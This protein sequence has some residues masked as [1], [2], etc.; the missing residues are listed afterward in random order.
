M[1]H[2]LSHFENLMGIQLKSSKIYLVFNK[3]FYSIVLLTV[4]CLYVLQINLA[5]CRKL[6]KF[7]ATSGLKIKI[8]SPG[9]E[10]KKQ[11]WHGAHCPALSV[12]GVMMQYR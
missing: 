10:Q 8:F 5:F 11:R 2:E 1:F 4:P 12:P 9:L 6:Q 3:K 7:S